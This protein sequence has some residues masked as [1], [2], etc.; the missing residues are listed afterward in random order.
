MAPVPSE[1]PQDGE[2]IEKKKI[3][4]NLK[5]IIVVVTTIVIWTFSLGGVYFTMKSKQDQAESKIRVLESRIDKYNLD[6]VMYRIDK[7]ED[8][9]NKVNEKADK[10]MEL[11]QK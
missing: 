10:I 7:L 2:D 9:T 3:T 4:F 8:G 5:T 6:L 1:I 11:L